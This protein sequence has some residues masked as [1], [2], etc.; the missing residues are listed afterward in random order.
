MASECAATKSLDELVDDILD[1]RGVTPLKLGSDFVPTGYRVISAKLI[2]DGRIDLSADE[3]R[4][5]DTPT[6]RKWMRTPLL[7]DDVLL[8]SEAP[9]GEAAYIKER[10]EWCLGQRLFG[11]RTH[12][13]R[14]YGRFLYYALHSEAVRQDLRS[15][16]TGTT[17]Q[18]IRQ[19]ELRRVRIALPSLDEQRAIAGILGALDDKID[20]NRR[21]NETLEAIA[22]ALFKSWFVD[23]DPVRAKAEG[24]DRS[25]PKPLADLFPD[26]FGNLE[27]GDIPK[28]WSVRTIYDCAEYVNGMAFGNDDFSAERLGLPVIK[29]AELKNG[30]TDQTKFSQVVLAPKYRVTSGDILFSWSGSPDTSIDTFVWA[31]PEGWLNQHVFK[32]VFKRSE[33]RSLVHLLLRHL[34]AVFVEIARNKQTTGLGHVTAQDLKRLVTVWPPDSVLQAFNRLA[35]PFLQE[36]HTKRLEAGALA[37]IR[38]ALLPKLISGELRIKDAERITASAL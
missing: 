34:R 21:M 19:S 13:E 26:S 35:D 25:L 23:F 38:D 24:R 22:R 28:G 27:A 29:I 15:R 16:A 33:D 14:L 12:K 18:G 20:L 30:I 2:K 8:T 11:I 37:A 10:L 1:R 4:F 9:L 5:V 17:A 32:V 36:M 6:Y 3:P 7:P 31:G